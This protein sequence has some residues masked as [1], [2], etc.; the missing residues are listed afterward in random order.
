M[1]LPLPVIDRLFD[2]LSATYGRDFSS[3]WEGLDTNNIKTSWAHE[4]GGYE[5]NLKAIAYALEHL[6][7]RAPNVIE[8]RNICTK[9]PANDAPMLERPKADP[10][11]A[12]MII[13]KLAAKPAQAVGRLDWAHAILKRLEGGAKISPTVVQM[14]KQALGA[15]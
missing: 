6:P 14:A 1:S 3:K 13:D 2:R 15:A 9:A 8:F 4:L 7:E 11:I 10:V 12:K 5:K